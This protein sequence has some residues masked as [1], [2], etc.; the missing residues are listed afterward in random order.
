MLA[1]KFNEAT[2]PQDQ[3]KQ[4]KHPHQRKEQSPYR[5]GCKGKPEYLL[6]AIHQERKHRRY[7][8]ADGEQYGN[9]FEVKSFEV[10]PGP[11][12]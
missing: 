2:S 5:S 11:G 12:Q 4:E 6:L 8:R 9:N 3:G 7:G 10:K 1:I